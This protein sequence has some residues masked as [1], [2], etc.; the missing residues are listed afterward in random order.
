MRKNIM[1]LLVMGMALLSGGLWAGVE[2]SFRLSGTYGHLVDGAGDVEEARKGWESNCF[3]LNQQDRYTTTFDWK[4]P[5]RSNDFRAEIMFRITRNFAVSIGSGYIFVKNQGSFAVD[6]DRTN[7]F[8]DSYNSENHSSEIYSPK[9]TLSAVPI[10]L[11]AYLFLPIGKKE[12]FTFF[13]HAGAGYYSGKL[14]FNLDVD[15]TSNSTETT[16]GELIYQRD[17]TQTLQMI[18]KTDSNSFGF[19]AGLGLDIKLTRTLSI[20]AEA[21]G[22]QVVF[23]NWEGSNVMNLETKSKSWSIWYGDS[24][25]EYSD[26]DSTYGNLWTYQSGSSDENNHYYYD[27][28]SG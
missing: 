24:E 14:D 9:G 4:T 5:K 18:Q 27:V 21:Y 26:T 15:G 28:G 13:A 7:N 20:G 10:T 2:V 23:R 6:Y 8:G 19:H 22:R 25:H 16:A 1:L 12:T 17:S 3:D 11:D